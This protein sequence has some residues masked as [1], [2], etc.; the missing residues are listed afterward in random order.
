MVPLSGI[1]G[2]L[3]EEQPE[4]RIGNRR[5]V[6]YSLE[7]DEPRFGDVTE[8]KIKVVDKYKAETISDTEFEYY[9]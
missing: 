2:R 9:D 6:K 3:E 4:K 1:Y 8:I 5:V 7:M